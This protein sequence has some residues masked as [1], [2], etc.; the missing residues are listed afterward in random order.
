MKYGNRVDNIGIALGNT[1]VHL[2]AR[3]AS[4]RAIA[5]RFA[6][7]RSLV[8]VSLKSIG[9]NETLTELTVRTCSSYYVDVA[10]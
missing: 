5:T 1:R 4:H 10:G 8:R 7:N 2:N 9:A 6:G 3:A